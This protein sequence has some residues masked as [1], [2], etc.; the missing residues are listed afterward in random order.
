MQPYPP[1]GGRSMN[2]RQIEETFRKIV[3]QELQG[4]KDDVLRQVNEIVKG[5]RTTLMERSARL[6]GEFNQISFVTMAIAALLEEKKVL[7]M[8]T[9]KL[10]AREMANQAMKEFA[11]MKKRD[12]ERKA[13]PEQPP[14]PPTQEKPVDAPPAPGPQ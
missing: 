7:D 6:T 9:V 13:A 8:E 14:T 11:E 5:M 12:E 1:Q 2:T 3:K 10:K 4:L